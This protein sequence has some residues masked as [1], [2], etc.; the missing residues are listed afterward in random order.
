MLNVIAAVFKNESEGYQ[1][2]TTLKSAPVSENAA[3]L[4][5]ELIRH[6]NNSYKV[7][8]GYKSEGAYANDTAAGGV[9][10]GL[11]GIIGGPLGVLLG[12]SAGALTGSIKDTAEAAAGQSMIE[13]VAGKIYD[14]TVSLVLLAD[15]ADESGID[16]MLSKY[17]AEIIRFSA[18]AVAA[19]IEEA[20]E[21][22]RELSRQ[23]RMELRQTRK[24]EH[25]KKAE[26]KIAQLN[27]DSEILRQNFVK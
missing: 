3:I 14:N 8:D 25:K 24:E 19:E 20:E 21:L 27:A 2:I 4:E 26:E 13:C 1:A 15:E 6:E 9:I 18:S 5:M 7:C 12:G 22:E 17:D 16:G 10:G 23:A 11:V